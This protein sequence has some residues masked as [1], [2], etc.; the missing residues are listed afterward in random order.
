MIWWKV[1]TK[2]Q[3]HMHAHTGPIPSTAGTGEKNPS[4]V[5]QYPINMPDYPA[6]EILSR[7]TSKGLQITVA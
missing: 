1:L 5:Q 6:L 7:A 2:R 4:E 3:T